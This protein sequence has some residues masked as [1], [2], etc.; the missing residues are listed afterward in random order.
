MIAKRLAHILTLFLLINPTVLLG[1]D[2][3]S[4]GATLI[5]N[6]GPTLSQLLELGLGLIAVLAMFVGLTWVLRRL[7]GSSLRK[8]SLL[9]I[10]AAISIG[11]RERLIL[12]RV[13]DQH[14]LLGVS[15]G[16]IRKLHDIEALPECNVQSAG[17]VD[18]KGAFTE[19]LKAAVLSREM[20]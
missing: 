2:M 10:I 6:E 16:N 4:R 13:A 11:P 5:D 3:Q 14:L 15:P 20:S 9:S 18:F 8:N 19:R 17:S 12:V 1:V 7:G